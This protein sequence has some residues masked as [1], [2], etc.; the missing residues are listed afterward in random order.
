MEATS[1]PQKV[2]VYI[3]E[4]MRE[5]FMAYAMSVIISRALPDVRDGLKPVHRR[6]LYAMYDASNTSDKPYKKSARLVGDIMGKYHPHGDTAIYDTIVRMAQ[7]FNL[8]YPLVD[9]QGN[10]GSID[11]DN[12]AAM[13]YTEIR[14]TPLAEEMLADIEKETVDFIANYDDSLKEPAVLPSRIPNLLI[15]GSAGIAVGMATNIPPHNLSEVIDGLIGL[16]ENPDITIKQLMRHIPGPDF[17]TAGFIHGKEPIVQAYHEGKG[18]VQMRGKAFTETVKRTGKEQVIISEIPYMVNKKRLIEQIADLVND[19]KIE[20][21]GDLR[22]ESD[23]EGMRIVIELKR[24]AVAEIVINQLYKHT[25]LQDSFGVNMLA[26]VDG[27]PKLLNLKE[28]LKA[29]LDHRKEVVT[30]RTAYDLRKAEERLHILEGYRIALDNLDAVIAL[31]R[32]SSDPRVAKEGLMSNF[33]LSDIQAQAILDLRLQRLTG[34]ERDKIMEEHRETVELIGKLRA[35]LADEKE[36]Y[37]I[38][39]E[40]LKEIKKKYGDERRT[41]IV[42][43]SDEISIEDTMVDEDMAVTISHEGYIK[44]NPVTLYRAQ[45]RGGKGKIGTT[46]KEE[47]FV[48]YLFIASMH[49]YILFF[50]TIGKVY[51]IKVHEL[52]QA[53]RAAR[54]KP[55]VNLLSLEPG[56]RVS[57][58]LTVREFQEGRYIVFAT[59]NGLI[60]KTELMAYANP[61]ASGI[62]AIGLEERDEVIGVRLTDGNQEIILSTAEGQSIRFKEEQVRPTG[63]GTFGVVGMKLDPEDKVVSMEILSLGVDI[64]TVAE[65]G[66]G[67]RTAMD[68]YRLQS[69]GGKGVI[70]M[71]TTD[72]TGRVIGVQLVTEED[73]LMMITNIG[74]IIRLRIKD[75]RVI[76]R[77]TQGVRLIELEEGERVVS[78]A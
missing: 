77:N 18:I 7:D 31:I 48:E 61:R 20:G 16:I 9:G 8:R 56:E 12:P 62:R 24:D 50:T 3:E 14:M 19:K 64:L 15:N 69:R 32:N 67:K 68:E 73:Q 25:A 17:P 11:G 57:A 63:R 10:F 45:R 38:I 23:R 71:K 41:Q 34:L 21:I 29:F 66:Y 33:A 51:W 65:G 6:V 78:V 36:I 39:V 5:S 1:R 35:I 76:G 46:T 2:P 4:E 13:R 54:G 75:I 59:K 40:E 47:D 53:S 37:R 28:A 55:I 26:I 60:K 58:F 43:R 52:P 22:D 27:K 44:R 42:D 72:K 30:R 74:K 70:T 49:S